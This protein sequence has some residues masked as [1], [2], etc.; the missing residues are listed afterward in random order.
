MKKCKTFYEAQT[1]NRPKE[2]IQPP[3]RSKLLTS[4]EQNF[5]AEIYKNI[6]TFAFQVL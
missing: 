5:L 2:I 6:K 4:L 3:T 1:A